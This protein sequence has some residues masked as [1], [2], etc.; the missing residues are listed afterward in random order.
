MDTKEYVNMMFGYGNGG[1]KIFGKAVK[2]ML[3]K[4]NFTYADTDSI[5]K[6]KTQLAVIKEYSVEEMRYFIYKLET[7]P[8]MPVEIMKQNKEHCIAQIIKFLESECKE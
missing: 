2:E 6:T 7:T 4:E 3:D 8:A 5:K 1:Q